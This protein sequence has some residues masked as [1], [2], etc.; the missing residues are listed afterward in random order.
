MAPC[1]KKMGELRNRPDS[2]VSGKC[3]AWRLLRLR[4]TAFGSE[5]QVEQVEKRDEAEEKRNAADA[6]ENRNQARDGEIERTEVVPEGTLFF[7]RQIRHV[8]Q[9]FRS[10][11]AYLES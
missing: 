1:R 2:W 5:A 11:W 10:S 6:V 4:V 8:K 7:R 9:S 3:G